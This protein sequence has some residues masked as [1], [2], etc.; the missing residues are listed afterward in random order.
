MQIEVNTTISVKEKEKG[1]AFLSKLGKKVLRPGGREL[2]EKLIAAMEVTSEDAVVEFAPGLGKSAVLL[3]EKNPKSYTGIDIDQAAIEKLNHK[4]GKS[5]VKFM[6]G[7]VSHTSLKD[8]SVA[9]ILAEAVLTMHADHRKR[10]MIREA[11]RILKVN[12]IIGIHELGIVPEN[13]DEEIKTEMTRD[14]AEISHVNAR[15]LTET[16][17]KNLLETEGF[18]VLEIMTNEMKLLEGKRLLADEGI[19]GALKIGFNVLTHP[20]AKH[21]MMK[22]R[23][24]FRKYSQNMRGIAITAQKI[25]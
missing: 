19:F 25:N 20:N 15:P 5:N 22:M 21:R 16:E 12:G 7:N 11:H 17:W 3:I 24:V 2:T 23:K 4:L 10:E 6:F 9:R 13:I 14:L 18:K 1:H 8:N